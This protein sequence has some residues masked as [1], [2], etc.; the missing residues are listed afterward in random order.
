[1]RALNYAELHPEGNHSETGYEAIPT[2]D[3]DGLDDIEPM[4]TP[5]STSV[6]GWL[7]LHDKWTIVS[8]LLLKYMLPLCKSFYEE[9]ASELN[10]FSVTVYLVS[11][12]EGYNEKLTSA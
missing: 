6:K 2:A 5:V 7:S 4:S 10:E 11:P 9:Y 3:V 1:M 8:P 12:L